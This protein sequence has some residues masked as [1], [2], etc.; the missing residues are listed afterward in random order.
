MLKYYRAA[1]TILG[2]NARNLDYTLPENTREARSIADSKL[3][4]KQILSR[5]GI[6][7]PLTYATIN[8]A[9]KLDAFDWNQ[10]P[11]SFVLKPNKGFAGQGILIV[12]GEKKHKE[13]GEEREW[14]RSDGSKVSIEMLYV[15]ILNILE[16]SF[17][18]G[19]APDRAYFEQRL[20]NINSLKPYLYRGVPDIRIIVYNH[21]PIMAMLRLPTKESNGKANIT[22]GAVGDG[23]DIASGITTTAV[24]HNTVIELHPDT[25]MKLSGISIPYWDKIL[26]MAI[27][28]QTA[29]N[30]GY[31]GVD[32][33]LDKDSGTCYA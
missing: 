13:E 31:I 7:V 6:P 1:K 27:T 23:I 18:L 14:I 5:A 19:N 21:V 20:R 4:A 28:A 22:I 2:R 3:K 29:T 11:S 15:H 17:S 12:Y 9:E 24:Q 10:L 32:I 25:R 16:G 26:E 8:S 33:A 30:L